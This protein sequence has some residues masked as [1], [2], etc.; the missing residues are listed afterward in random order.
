MNNPSSTGQA[1]F[2][3]PQMDSEFAEEVND[4]IKF[5]INFSNFQLGQ[6]EIIIERVDD[7]QQFGGNVGADKQQAHPQSQQM[8]N[9]MGKRGRP[10]KYPQQQMPGTSGGGELQM[11]GKEEEEK[12]QKCKKW[13]LGM[14]YFWEI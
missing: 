7:E 4:P 11:E 13:R 8:T 1:Q 14:E 6:E 3:Q 2:F 5:F 12:R 10:T 9:G